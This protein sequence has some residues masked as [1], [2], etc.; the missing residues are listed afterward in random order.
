MTTRHHIYI[1]SLLLLA[2]AASARLVTEVKPTPVFINERASYIVKSASPLKFR[3]LPS[4]PKIQWLS[5]QANVSQTANLSNGVQTREYTYTFTFA[6]RATGRIVI[7]A[8]EVEAQGKKIKTAAVR[9]TA[10]SKAQGNTDNDV[11]LKVLYNGKTKPPAEIYLGQDVVI[12]IVL[13]VPEHLNLHKRTFETQQHFFPTIELSNALLRDFPNSNGQP[14]KFQWRSGS[15]IVPADPSKPGRRFIAVS[16]T[17]ST[18]GL[19]TGTIDGEIIH[20]VPI[21]VPG[22]NTRQRRNNLISDFW[23]PRGSI[24]WT[25]VK[26]TVPPVNVKPLPPP[27]DEDGHFL[28]LIGD[29]DVGVTVS[30]DVVR[31][32]EDITLTLSVEGDGNISRLT[33]PKLDRDLPGF[34]VYPPEVVRAA[35]GKSRGAVKWALVPVNTEATLPELRFLTFD[36]KTGKYLLKT[37]TPDLTVEAG[38]QPTLSNPINNVG[39]FVPLHTERRKATGILHIKQD[40]GNYLQLPLWHSAQVTVTAMG[41]AAPLLYM[42]IWLLAARREKLAGSDSFRR[43]KDAAKN[44][45]QVFRS[46]SEASRDKLPDVVRTELIPYVLA[47]LDLPPGTTTTELKEQLDDKEL[48]AMIEMAEVGGFMPGS[49]SEIDATRLLQHVRKLVAILLL[50][51]LVVTATADELTLGDAPLADQPTFGDA[52]Q[53]Y[54]SDR[55]D[56]AATIYAKQQRDGFG[57]ASV[58]FNLANCKFRE[59]DYG[60]AVILYERARRLAPRDSDIVENLNFVR[61]QL[62][63]GKVAVNED[64][65]SL[66]ANQRDKLRQDEWLLAAGAMWCLCWL[67]FALDRWRRGGL[68]IPATVFGIL[69]V[70]SVWA[71]AAQ[72]RTTYNTNQG[73]I[74]MQD[75]PVYRLPQ[76]N[77]GKAKIVLDAGAYVTIAE[78]R[79]EWVRIRIDEA[80]G[81]VGRAA[82]EQIW[83]GS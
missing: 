65:L 20:K 60:K 58:L 73:V 30:P 67:M 44:R 77:A 42:L 72:S 24:E 2:G 41:V 45:N 68:K 23:G 27:T 26:V 6:A 83:P 9:L 51:L 64:P 57:N 49:D 40:L 16:Y 21:M 52:A 1:L 53:A 12:E 18:S 5:N 56:A 47:I 62:N 48:A 70:L 39:E 35:Q 28:G 4:S 61:A 36:T 63:L 71:Y 59:S 80:E 19:Q 25:G 17:A 3:T 82:V 13:L 76:Q 81:W 31:V 43:R 78:K 46:V 38:E 69:C 10:H 54:E 50:P 14:S 7:P 75:T 55:V 37:V 79:T 15:K 74:V 8:V 34:K 33:A 22:K 32:G 29:W 66:I 11:K